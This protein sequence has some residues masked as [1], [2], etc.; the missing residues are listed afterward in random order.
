M[1]S[2]K[3]NQ[4]I[5]D[6]NT[7]FDLAVL[8]VLGDRDEQQ[9]NFGYLLQ[10]SA[11]LVVVCDG[12]GGYEGGKKAS[13]MAVNTFLS[14]YEQKRSH[15][16]AQGFLQQ[17]TL[18]ANSMVKDLQNSSEKLTNAGS[19]LLAVLIEDNSLSWSGAGDSRAYLLRDDQLVQITQDH[20]YRSVLNM[21]K[22]GSLLDLA[23]LAGKEKKEEALIS[24]LG[25]T[26]LKLIDYNQKPLQLEADDKIVIMTDGLYKLVSDQEMARIIGNFKNISESLLALEMKAKRNAREARIRRDNMTVALL[27]IK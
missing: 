10:D 3:D 6:E 15:D 5:R 1:Q 27:R 12:M 23:N 4:Q 14:C 24:F 8:T 26:E 17:A 21:Q 13:R 9:D 11:G 22:D 25:I 19:T 16:D 7:V 18:L 20:N 2:H